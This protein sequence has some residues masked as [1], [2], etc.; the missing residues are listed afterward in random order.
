MYLIQKWEQIEN[1]PI[2]ASTAFFVGDALSFNGSGDVV[3]AAGLGLPIMGVGLAPIVSTDSDYASADKV[4]PYQR[5]KEGFRFQCG[6]GAG[7][8]TAAMIG[9]TYNV[10]ATDSRLIDVSAYNTLTYNTLAVGVFAVASTITGTTSGATGVITRI[11]PSG[12]LTYTVT[13]GTFVTGETITDSVTGA[14]AK[15]DNLITGGTQLRV[16]NFL[17]AT[18]VEVEVVLAA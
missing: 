15:I 4:M 9:K 3:R 18:S 13:A 5:V 14:T 2:P 17:S 1:T 12:Q 10:F 7:T 16:V 11:L 6:V 8:A